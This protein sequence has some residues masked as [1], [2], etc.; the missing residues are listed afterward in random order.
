MDRLM[1]L[2]R[3]PCRATQGI[4]N[5]QL[6]GPLL[7]DGCLMMVAGRGSVERFV[8]RRTDRF[9]GERLEER[10]V[11]ARQLDRREALRVSRPKHE[12]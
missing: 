4:C 12:G 10:G 9:R 7:L 6:R 5:L 1:P 8:V 3:G 11:T 2:P